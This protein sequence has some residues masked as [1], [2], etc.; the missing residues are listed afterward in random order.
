MNYLKTLSD[1]WRIIW[2]NKIL[3]IYGVV[4]AVSATVFITINQIGNKGTLNSTEVKVLEIEIRAFAERYWVG[5]IITAVAVLI[6]FCLIIWVSVISE[7]GLIHE[8]NTAYRND[9]VNLKRGWK[10]GREKFWQ[11]VGLEILIG[12]VE[13]LVILMVRMPLSVLYRN[14]AL[15][16]AIPLT[17]FI[18]LV[19]IP[20]LLIAFSVQILGIRKIIIDDKKIFQAILESYNLFIDY[21]KK[22]IITLLILIST[23]VVTAFLYTIVCLIL[24]LP[25][26]II[27]LIIASLIG[28]NSGGVPIGIFIFVIPAI[29]FSVFAIMMATVFKESLWSVFYEKIKRLSAERK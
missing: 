25:V 5:I 20:F 7:I 27:A 1:T 6:I 24:L 11:V 14:G 16:V 18:I 21:W 12:A 2:K 13:F 10:K 17:V 9:N 4:L 23:V 26:A 15:A 3:W 22:I 28:I 8:A 29:P 19:L